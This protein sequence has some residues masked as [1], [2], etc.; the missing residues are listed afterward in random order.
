MKSGCVAMNLV[1]SQ[2]LQLN[3]LTIN[4]SMNDIKLCYPSHASKALPNSKLHSPI[5]NEVSIKHYLYRYNLIN[6]AQ[7]ELSNRV[8]N[9]QTKHLRQ[10]FSYD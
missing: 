10:S 7:E 9:V 5:K 1:Q 3:M 2:Y 6:T 8:Y 4:K